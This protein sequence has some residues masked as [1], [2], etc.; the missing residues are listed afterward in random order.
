M[1]AYGGS[2]RQRVI[3]TMISIIKKHLDRVSLI[4]LTTS[5]QL[6]MTDCISIEPVQPENS[7]LP[8]ICN[9]GSVYMRTTWKLES[10]K[11]YQVVSPTLSYTSPNVVTQIQQAKHKN[12]TLNLPSVH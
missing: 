2:S 8:D 5:S 1:I 6:K 7:A 3:Y 10:G 9:G 12:G 4:P 11:Q